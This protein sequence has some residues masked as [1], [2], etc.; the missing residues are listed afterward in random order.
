MPAEAADLRGGLLRLGSRP[1]DLHER[2]LR[3]AADFFGA[4][5]RGG[6]PPKPEQFVAEVVA[7]VVAGT[8]DAEVPMP[9]VRRT[10]NKKLARP[11]K[12]A[13]EKLA[14]GPVAEAPEAREYLMSHGLQKA[15]RTSRKILSYFLV[16]PHLWIRT[17]DIARREKRD[18]SSIAPIVRTFGKA[19][20]V[21]RRGGKTNAEWKLAEMPPRV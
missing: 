7:E 15:G 5:A 12:V 11:S 3:Y 19:E 1:K 10:Y 2:F 14:P 16:Y 17:V 8:V 20:I 4:F 13:T 21:V 18:P 6:K 9:L